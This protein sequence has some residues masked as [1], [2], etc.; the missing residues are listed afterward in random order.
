M[1]ILFLNVMISF[2]S[3]FAM[4][5]KTTKLWE[6]YE[7][8]LC[9]DYVNLILTETYGWIISPIVLMKNL[10]LSQIKLCD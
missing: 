10:K 3:I 4:S 2:D 9:A 8:L 6:Y 1:K 5:E 7:H